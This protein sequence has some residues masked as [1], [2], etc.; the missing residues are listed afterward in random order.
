MLVDFRPIG[1]LRGAKP[2][3]LTAALG[4]VID[5]LAQDSVDLSRVRVVCDWVQYRSNFRDIVDLRQILADDEGG[6]AGD[7]GG[8]NTVPA[9]LSAAWAHDEME[10]AIDVRRCG[11]VALG[12]LTGELIRGRFAATDPSRLYL[13]PW[14]ATRRSVIW[15]FNTLY[16]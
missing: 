3:D 6:K 13:E 9:P 12:E 2:V 8:A 14:L 11:D 7:G 10:V 15:E 16:W 1:R 5:A 4:P